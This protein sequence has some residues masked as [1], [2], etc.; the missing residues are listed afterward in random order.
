[1]DNLQNDLRRKLSKGEQMGKDG[2]KLPPA[3]KMYVMGWDCNMELQVHEQVEQCKTVSHPGFGVNQNKIKASRPCNATEL[4]NKEVKSWWKE[5]ALKQINQA[6]VAG[7]DIFSRLAYSENNVFACSYHYCGS[8]GLNF[9]C[10]YNKN[11]ATAGGTDLYTVAQN[12]FCGGCADCV[13][14]LCPKYFEPSRL[15]SKVCPNCDPA[16]DYFRESALYQHNYYRRILATGWAEDKKIMYAKPAKAMLELAYDKGLEDAAK[17]YIT[18][19]N[20]NC[21]EKAENVALTGENFYMDNNFGL[22]NEEVIKKAV[23]QW[24]SP[25]KE[26]GFANDLQYDNIQDNDVKALANVVHD[27]TTKMGCAARTCKPQGIIVVDCRYDEKIAAGE[28]VYEI[29]K[30]P[31]N[32]CP[33]GKTC[34]KLGGLCV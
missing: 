3:G 7:N 33:N 9:A 29:G 25:L 16:D 18:N 26:K 24:W 4:T 31:C 30:K 6:R 15:T 13:N 2:I 17:K 32:P 27:K 8:E 10:F 34:S 28:N 12:G 1:M 22:T 11:G 20:L 23:E 21:P 14:G 19:N 5:G